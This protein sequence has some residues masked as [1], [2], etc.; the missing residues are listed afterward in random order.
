MSQAQSIL[1]LGGLVNLLVSVLVSYFLYW[2]RVRHPEI[3]AQRYGLVS[4]KV[5]LWNGFLLL[6]LSVAI[7]HSGYAGYVN[8]LLAGAEVL[9]TLVSGTGNILRWSQ[10]LEDQFRQGPEWRVR[11]IGFFHIIDLMVI[12][13]ILVGVTRTVLGLW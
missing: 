3:P 12:S 4:H 10:S 6:G 9:G 11:A 5:T 13:A 8:N 2:Q 1:I 7:D